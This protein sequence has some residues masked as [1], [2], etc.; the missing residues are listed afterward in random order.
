[1]LPHINEQSVQS[2]L[3]LAVGT[4]YNPLPA[5]GSGSRPGPYAGKYPHI[6]RERE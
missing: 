2:P 1:L 4:Y 5:P 3:K 6:G